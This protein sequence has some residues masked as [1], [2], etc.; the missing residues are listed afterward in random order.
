[1]GPKTLGLFKAGVNKVIQ[2]YGK[3]GKEQWRDLVSVVSPEN[4]EGAFDVIKIAGLGYMEARD[5]G[6]PASTDSKRKL[7]ETRF[8]PT[9]FVKLVELDDET[10]RFDYYKMAKTTKDF[11]YVYNQTKNK[12]I[13][14]LYNNGF[15][16]ACYDGDYWF[17]TDH[18]NCPGVSDSSNLLTAAL[19]TTALQTA[20]TTLISQVDERGLP[21]LHASGMDLI[22]GPTLYPLA[23]EL[24]QA[25]GKPQTADNDKNFASNWVTPKINNYITS[26][27]SYFLK[28]TAEEEFGGRVIDFGQ[29]I[30][31][32]QGDEVRTQQRLTAGYC[33]YTPA[34]IDWHGIVA[35]S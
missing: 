21:L 18:S 34:I 5:P 15:T 1:M 8:Y 6:E 26:T 13:A 31:Y 16:V 9:K 24:C 17:D 14:D 3:Q 10:E 35:K 7:Y 4:G 19:S 27:T 29:G 23:W 22:V 28:R 20:I 25:G 2:L 30:K 32:M 12:I 11:V 33:F